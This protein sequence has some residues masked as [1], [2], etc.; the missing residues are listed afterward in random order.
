MLRPL[1]I[2]VVVVVALGAALVA[3]QTQPRPG[4]T[5]GIVEVAGR[6]EVANTPTVL[7]QQAGQWK[8]AV[9]NVPDIRVANVPTVSVATPDFLTKG[10]R[11]EIAWAGGASEIV[12]IAQTAAGGWVR[13]A[14]SDRQR[15]INLAEVRA[16]Q[17]VR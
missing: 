10:S 8:V 12:E 7:S 4:P 6:V 16:M 3:Q 5:S 9:A 1:S 13:I 11:W 15:W 2:V 14:G 17:E